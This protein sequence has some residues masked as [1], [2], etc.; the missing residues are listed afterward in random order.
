M[1]TVTLDQQATSPV[2][3]PRRNG[4]AIHA[5]LDVPCPGYHIASR[6]TTG[7][8][9]WRRRQAGHRRERDRR[10]Q[11]ECAGAPRSRLTSTAQ[12]QTTC[13][14]RRRARS[15]ARDPAGNGEIDL[16]HGEAGSFL[17]SNAP[18]NARTLTVSRARLQACHLRP[19]GGAQRR[20]RRPRQARQTRRRAGHGQPD[21]AAVRGDPGKCQRHRRPLVLG[22][23]RSASPP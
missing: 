16:V 7:G 23:R 6:T 14:P 11:L 19:G 15:F 1:S 20:H 2:A 17:L 12:M 21:H 4:R 10:R 8:L 9:R 13:R 5:Q 22:D 3:T 18:F